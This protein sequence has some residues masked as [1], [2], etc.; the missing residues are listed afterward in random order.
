[1]SNTSQTYLPFIHIT[2]PR[3]GQTRQ[4]SSQEKKVL[5]TK[6]TLPNSPTT[7]QSPKVQQPLSKAYLKQ[8]SSI[9]K[10]S[11]NSTDDFIILSP[12]QRWNTGTPFVNVKKKLT[13][14]ADSKRQQHS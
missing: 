9:L 4:V 2:D 6:Q 13:S 11:E 7:V 5:E 10:N 12:T 3:W 1:M 8:N 14:T